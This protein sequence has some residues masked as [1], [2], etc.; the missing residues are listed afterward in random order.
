MTTG[1]FKKGKEKSCGLLR[2]KAKVKGLTGAPKPP[3][4]IVQQ[5]ETASALETRIKPKYYCRAVTSECVISTLLHICCCECDRPCRK[6]HA[7]WCPSRR[8]PIRISKK[9]YSKLTGK[10]TGYVGVTLRMRSNK[11]YPLATKLLQEM[12]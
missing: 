4:V 5:D 9:I 8:A 7:R 2:C 1:E 10:H 6:Y 12:F 11:K 3:E